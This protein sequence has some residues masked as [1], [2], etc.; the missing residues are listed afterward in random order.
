MTDT[1]LDWFGK[2]IVKR[3]GFYWLQIYTQ[4]DIVDCNAGD[5]VSVGYCIDDQCG[6]Q[7]EDM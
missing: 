1:E 4:M 7:L 6:G 3:R 2:I 5:H